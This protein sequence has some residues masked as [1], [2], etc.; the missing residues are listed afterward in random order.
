M[1]KAFRP[2]LVRPILGRAAVLAA[3]GGI[4]AGFA[5]AQS[6]AAAKEAS[7]QSPAAAKEASEPDS[8]RQWLWTFDNTTLLRDERG[9]LIFVDES[10]QTLPS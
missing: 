9:E 7:E 1:W 2:T 5:Y 10:G 6:P 8:G 3:G 4:A